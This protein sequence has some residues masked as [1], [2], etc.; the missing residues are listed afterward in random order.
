MIT[1]RE[2]AELIGRPYHTVRRWVSSGVVTGVQAIVVEGR[3]PV[4]HVPRSAVA[5]FKKKQPRRGRPPR[6]KA[7]R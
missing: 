2:F 5:E 7:T 6:A 3:G 4:Y 1:V